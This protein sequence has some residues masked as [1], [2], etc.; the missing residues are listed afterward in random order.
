MI[1]EIA[2]CIKL[3]STPSFVRLKKIGPVGF[4]RAT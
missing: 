3:Y 4:V 2:A 1:F